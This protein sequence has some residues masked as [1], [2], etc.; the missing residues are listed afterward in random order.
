M[1]GQRLDVLTF[2]DLQVFLLENVHESRT[3]EFKSELVGLKDE[4]KREFLA[5]VSAFA[6]T[7]GG[8][9]IFGVEAKQGKAIAVRGWKQPTRMPR[10]SD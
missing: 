2:A 8:D 9:L 3:L 1:L 10:F 7:S 4:D 6:N 5:D